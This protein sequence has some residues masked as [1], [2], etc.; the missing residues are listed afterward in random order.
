[1]KFSQALDRVLETIERPPV[2]PVGHYIWQI[3]KHPELDEFESQKTGTTY[4]RVTFFLTC[5]AACDDV[6]PDALQEYGNPQ[7]A[8]NRKTFLFSNADED[9]VSFDRSMFNLRQFLD[10]AGVDSSLPINEGFAASVGQQIKGEINHRLD[11][12]NSEIVYAEIGTTA[13]V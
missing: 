9:K 13:P 4:E 2:L 3:S 1:M 8:L 6:G 12:Q 7:G 5:V 10:A 11:P